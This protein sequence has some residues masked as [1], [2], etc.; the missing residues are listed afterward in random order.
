MV[1]EDGRSR[2]IV[3]G[4]L[5]EHPLWVVQVAGDFARAFDAEVV[6]VAVDPARYAFQDLPDGSLMTA[7]LDPGLLQPSPV[8]DPAARA[9]LGALL[10]PSGVRW[11]VR[12]ESGDPSAALIRVAD[13][14]DALM[15]VVGAPRGGLR[16]AMRSVIQGSVGA[17]LAQRQYRPVVVVPTAPEP[18]EPDEVAEG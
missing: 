15:L 8:L 17:R 10:E 7:P 5:P 14:V 6:C 11:S 12:E 9:A 16:G 3:A 1:Q 4:V 13:E 2:A 18:D